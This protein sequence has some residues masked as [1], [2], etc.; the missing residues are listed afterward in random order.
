MPRARDASNA[1]RPLLLV[2]LGGKEL[3]LIIIAKMNKTQTKKTYYCRWVPPTVQ[4][5]V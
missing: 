1:S 2:S 4:T 3:K 5:T